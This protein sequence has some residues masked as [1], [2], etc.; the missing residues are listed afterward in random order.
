MPT[1]PAKIVLKWALEIESNGKAF[2]THVADAVTDRDAKALFTDLAYQEERHYRTFERMLEGADSGEGSNADA[3][4][5]EAYM[6]AAL[7]SALVGSPDRGLALAQQADSEQAAIEAAMAFEKD[8]LLFFYDVRENV[9][10]DQ[11][12]TVTAVIEQERIHLRQLA[13]ILESGPWAS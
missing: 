6:K 9:P 10:E 4:K 11:K 13:Q 3:A 1:L 5:Y 12:A 7:A 8:T 2:Y